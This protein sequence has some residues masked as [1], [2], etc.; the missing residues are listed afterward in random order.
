M[1]KLG[2]ISW[3]GLVCQLYHQLALLN[4]ARSPQWKFCGQNYL[5]YD[6]TCKGLEIQEISYDLVVFWS[7]LV[8]GHVTPFSIEI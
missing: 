5:Y 2:P 3:L 7:Q 8:G 1:Q 4:A 6:E